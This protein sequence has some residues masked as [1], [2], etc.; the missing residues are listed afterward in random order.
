MALFLVQIQFVVMLL[1][2]RLRLTSSLT[3]LFSVT[4]SAKLKH[5][6]EN[7]KCV[8]VVLY[9]TFLSFSEDL[10][11]TFVIMITHLLPQVILFKFWICCCP[12]LTTGTMFVFKIRLQTPHSNNNRKF[13]FPQ[14]ALTFFRWWRKC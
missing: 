10:L 1:V 12:W 14:D 7:R 2:V 13:L 9:P 6:I 11:W 5:N 8:V 4:L 3:D